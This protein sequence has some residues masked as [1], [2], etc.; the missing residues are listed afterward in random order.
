[1]EIT[2]RWITAVPQIWSPGH[3]GPVNVL[4]EGK[5]LPHTLYPEQ[6]TKNWNK[7]LPKV[8]AKFSTELSKQTPLSLS[9]PLSLV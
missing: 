9:H 4:L 5:W 2:V 7:I 8:L 6:R 1:M 3:E